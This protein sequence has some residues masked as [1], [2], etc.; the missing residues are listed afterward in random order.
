MIYQDGIEWHPIPD[1]PGYYASRDGQIGSAYRVVRGKR[2][3]PSNYQI[4]NSIETVL[5]QGYCKHINGVLQVGLF[6]NRK[7]RSRRVHT[8]ILA[9]F[10][11][12]CPEGMVA[13]HKNGNR[14]DNRLENLVYGT[15][16][17]MIDA[18]LERGTWS[19][20]ERSG[21]A[22]LTSEEIREIRNL[23]ATGKWTKRML[24]EK[25]FITSVHASMLVR[26]VSRVTAPEDI[27][28]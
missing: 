28:P 12:P 14:H 5:K 2:V 13:W 23:R 8:L 16:K 20:G 18:A 7:R 6:V 17:E 25:F 4:G 3:G 27:A 10:V 26:E 22:K 24:A 19:N 21:L 9:A 15:R 1:H 11:G